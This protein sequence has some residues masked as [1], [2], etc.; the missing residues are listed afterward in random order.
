MTIRRTTYDKRYFE[1]VFFRSRPNS[2]RNRNRLELILAN[3]PKGKL[4]EVGP[5]KG[6]FLQLAASHF[7]VW[8]FEISS[9]AASRLPAPLRARAVVGDVE[10]SPLPDPPFDVI[11]AFNLLEH[12]H[13]PFPAIQKIFD[14]LAPTGIFVGSVPCNG[15]LAGTVHSALT[16]LFDRTHVS[17]AKIGKWQEDFQRAG[18]QDVQLFGEVMIGPNHSKYIFAR[19]WRYISFNMMFLCRKS[20]LG[21][22]GSSV[23]DQAS[24]WSNHTAEPG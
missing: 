23:P 7:E 21:V 10:K 19:L 12:L 20:E 1:S 4:L 18:F 5:A 17:N 24:G 13:R 15:G 2:P 8:G 3:K 6:E 16:D 9:Y 14:A 22:V 11:A